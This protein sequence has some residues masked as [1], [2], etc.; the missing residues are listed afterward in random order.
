MHHEYNTMLMLLYILLYGC[1]GSNPC[2]CMRLPFG[3]QGMAKRV[4]VSEFPE[5]ARGQQGHHSGS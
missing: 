3:L 4:P 5:Q 1:W 2:I